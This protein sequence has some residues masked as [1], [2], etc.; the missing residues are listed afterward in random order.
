VGRN[1]RKSRGSSREGY[2]DVD[3]EDR[4]SQKAG[5]ISLLNWKKDGTTVG[6]TFFSQ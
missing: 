1:E 5:K 3:K 4:A 6:T 2:H